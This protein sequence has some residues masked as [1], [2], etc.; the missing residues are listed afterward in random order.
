MVFGFDMLGINNHVMFAD[1]EKPKAGPT[2]KSVASGSAIKEDLG[3]GGRWGE[4]GKSLT[5]MDEE[6]LYLVLQPG[7]EMTVV[8]KD[9]ESGGETTKSAT[10]SMPVI[11]I[12]GQNAVVRM[13]QYKN[14]EGEVFNYSTQPQL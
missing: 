2:F 5:L 10:G 12:G 1:A 4:G 6:N 14:P 7:H 3:S 13:K 8:V 9:L 11:Q